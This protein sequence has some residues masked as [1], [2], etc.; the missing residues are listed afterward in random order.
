MSEELQLLQETTVRFITSELPRE[1]TRSL[2]DDPRGYDGA[3]FRRSAELGWYSML[4][5]EAH[6][7]GSVTGSPLR[8]L[9][10]VAD[11][12][13]RYVQPGPFVP[14][15]VVAA[16]IAADGSDA[17]QTALLPD[18]ATGAQVATWAPFGDGGRWDLGQGL[19]VDRSGDDLVV[20]GTRT[21]VQDAQTAGV[22]L[23]VG[24]I[25]GV[26]AQL[27]V[28]I[29]ADG[30]T[31]EPLTCLDL[32]R[33]MADIAFDGV[34]VPASAL[35]GS[36]GEPT[37]GAL[38]RQ[39]HVAVVLA[40][41]EIVGV[42]DELFT[43]T[44]EYSR[45]RVAFGRPIG[46]FQALKHAMADSLAYLETCKAVTE[47]A[48]RAVDDGADDAAAIVSMAASYLDERGT[49]VA[50]Q[51]LQIHGGIGFTWEHDLHLLMRRAKSTAS[52]WCDQVWH[53]E[54]LCEVHGL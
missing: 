1:A 4:V 18:L 35:V 34:R 19:V 42:L 30:L 33:R 43:M 2:H 28:P 48:A 5:P 46:S 12:I 8:D 10:V 21:F 17:Q 13:G 32:S 20:H 45:S 47:E 9:A 7:G 25:D 50:Q 39:L 51:C 36:P 24:S 11:A 14:M 40:C 16:A 29:E 3:W 6:G 27:L 22:V 44:V 31:I 54:R 41:A 49:A 15:N 26:P 37:L 53:R 52:M 23:A 38:E